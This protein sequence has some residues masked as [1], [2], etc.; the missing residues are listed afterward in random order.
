M[1]NFSP[2]F[3]PPVLSLLT[4]YSLAAVSL[5]CGR[6]RKEN[7]LLALVC[8]WWTLLSYIFIYHNLVPDPVKVIA[9]ERLVHS[10]FVFIPLIT[11]LF[12]QV[13]TDRVNKKLIFTCFLLST[14]FAFLV[15]T[16][17]Y[18]SGF[19]FYRWGMVARGGTAF[20]GFSFYAVCITLYIFY[21][22]LRT[23]LFEK[24]PATR[25]KLNYLIISFTVSAV[26]TISNLPAMNGID[27]YPLSN[28]IFIPLGIMTYGILKYRLA[29][30]SNVLHMFIFWLMLSSIIAVPNIFIFKTV[31][32]LF[33]WMNSFTLFAV[34]VIWFLANYYYFNRV[35]PLINQ[36]FN[37]RNYDLSMMEKTFIRDMA[38]LKNLDSLVN[39]MIIMLQRTIH[40]KHASLFIKNGYDGLYTDSGGNTLQINIES[41]KI[42]YMETF[43]EKSLIESDH[44]IKKSYRILLPV[45][46]K[47][48]SEYL[49]PLIHQNEIIA[50]LALSKRISHKRLKENEIKFILD[51]STYATIAL[52]NSVMYQNLSDIKDHLEKIVEDRTSVIERQ[53]SDL[54]RDIQLA[55]KIQMSLLPKKI[56]DLKKIKI[57]YRY[58]PIM[59]VGGDFIDIH[60]RDG[61]DELGLFICDVS[62][63]G[64]SSAMIASMIKMALHSW[65]T[66]IQRPALAFAEIK[67]LLK[68]K[69]GDNFISAFM[70]CIDINS[71]I[72]TSACAG[73]PPMILLRKDGS[74]EIIKPSGI[75][76]LDLMDSEYEEV[77]TILFN[78]DKIVLYTDG[79]FEARD[80]SGKMI[81]EDR[82][83]NILSKNHKLS[84]EGLCQ[85]VYNEIFA[86]EG[87]IIDDD[88]ALLIAEY[89][90]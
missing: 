71:G 59:G 62:G 72:M 45:F 70:C 54:E 58:E 6:L 40:I 27:F 26:F 87:N 75:I 19:H 34:F 24:N 64:A 80:S 83:I 4:G 49:F 66:F 36:L 85:K 55:R 86:P 3:I 16:P 10:F 28:F 42:I 7:I 84:A 33:S 37:K 74:L 8:F 18:F 30:I 48:E 2:F 82:L 17:W 11:V 20:Y 76:L 77:Q 46:H 44:G 53:K 73:H 88:F 90:E 68:N 81:G 57:A 52:A 23:I 31:T 47:S 25:L 50:L 89:R 35:Q 13:I 67:N 1:N 12:F 60:Y 5:I 56:P 41:E 14:V 15:Y 63:H 9:V 61:M 78:G 79:V 22:M 43:F 69:I 39:E 51:I 65:G 38:E 29:G 32:S 21:F